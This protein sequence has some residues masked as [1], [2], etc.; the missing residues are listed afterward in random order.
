MT[1]SDILL[2]HG[3]IVVHALEVNIHFHHFVPRGTSSFQYVSQ[4]RDALSLQKELALGN[5]SQ[6]RMA[7]WTCSVGFDVPW[8]NVARTVYRHLPS[9]ED[10]ARDLHRMR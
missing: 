5:R 4:V 2:V 7:Q 9:A 3:R 8:N 1:D 10:K 6:A